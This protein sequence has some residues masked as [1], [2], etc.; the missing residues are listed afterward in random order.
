ME[1]GAEF[2]ITRITENGNV[3][4]EDRVTRERPLTI[5]LNHRE[6]VTLLCSPDQLEALAVGFLASEGFVSRKEDIEMLTVDARRGIVRVAT[7]HAPEFA[8]EFVFKR[9]I[10]TGCGR[11]A[12][13]YSPTDAQA[14]LRVTAQLA[15]AP[16]VIFT[17]VKEFQR[18]S[19]TYR[20]TGGVHSAA[21]CD[22]TRILLFA[23]DIGRHNAIDKIFGQCLLENQPTAGL[24]LITSGRI[25]SEILLKVARRNVPV[26]V[27][28]SA[29]TDLGVTLA[30]QLGITLV[31][32]VRGQRMNVY[33]HPHRI[34]S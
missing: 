7:H 27:S 8:E 31:G 13:F 26:I 10:T 19:E 20:A 9:F 1:Q 15:V 17:L 25:S 11:G 14:D 3:A 22:A 2:V 12:T 5:L 24:M 21:L 23:E 4:L 33:T 29:P 30:E 6:L 16:A 18:R 34:V 32:F 28:K